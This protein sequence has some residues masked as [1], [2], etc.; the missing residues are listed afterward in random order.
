MSN[1]LPTD[2]KQRIIVIVF[3]VTI[4]VIPLFS[5][6]VSQRTTISKANSDPRA[7]DLGTVTEEPKEVPKDALSQLQREAA[8][9]ATSSSSTA[10]PPSEPE[11]TTAVS[12]GPTLSFRISIEG[13]PVNNQSSK[14]FFVGIAAGEPTD[15]PTYLLSFTVDIPASGIFDSISLAGLE[16]GSEYTAYLKGSAQVATTSAFRMSPGV[17]SLNN[18]TTLNLL[19]GDLNDDN[20]I[21]TA[22]YSLAKAAFGSTPS[23]DNWSERAD[24]NLDN[25]VNTID[26]G[27]V[28]RNLGQTGEDGAWYST[29]ESASQSAVPSAVG[30]ASGGYW[31]WVPR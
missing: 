18:G 21:N 5:M 19:S 30:G 24:L 6:V 20:V 17:S 7:F 29:T 25:V 22:D 15:N 9:Q 3:V 28:I 1:I 14:Q 31:I 2:T 13:R 12:F 27:I 11:Q 26:L 23:S 16:S 10:L 4:I 8:M